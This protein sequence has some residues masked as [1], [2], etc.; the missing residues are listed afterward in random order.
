LYEPVLVWRPQ[1]YAL[2]AAAVAVLAA[3]ALAFALASA[4]SRP[5]QAHPNFSS[6]NPLILSSLF[7]AMRPAFFQKATD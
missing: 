3:V 7:R 6:D 1:A 5:V 2:A 4:V